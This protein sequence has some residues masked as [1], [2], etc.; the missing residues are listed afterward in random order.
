MH[1]LVFDTETTGLLPKRGDTTADFPRLVQIAFL[2]YCTK[3]GGLATT[4]L[5]VNPGIPVPL[6]ASKVHG[7]TT[8]QAVA[9]GISPAEAMLRL[10]IALDEADLLVAHNYAYDSAIVANECRVAD[11]VDVIRAS[12]VPEYCTMRAG[13]DVCAIM[14]PR[15]DGTLYVKY[16]KL[17]ELY[18]ELF[19]EPPN[20]RLHD[21]RADCAA[22]LRCYLALM[23]LPEPGS[24]MLAVGEDTMRCT[25]RSRCLRRARGGNTPSPRSS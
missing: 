6:G 18:A 11:M 21:A 20:V 15:K 2:S 9:E 17:V 4:S 12:R 8:E 7:I 1:I 3:T 13:T 14:R 19:G 24:G 5:I 10:S 16:P 23:G 25:S 22:T